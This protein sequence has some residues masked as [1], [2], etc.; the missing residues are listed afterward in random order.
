MF[1]LFAV[2]A[3]ILSAAFFVGNKILMARYEMPWIE[4][5]RWGLGATSLCGIVAYVLL[6]M[7]SLPWMWV[8]GAGVS[9]AF[10][11]VLA[12]KALSWGDA[13]FL[14]PISGA[15]PLLVA[16]LPLVMGVTLPDTIIYACLLSTLGIAL[17]VMIPP[18]AHKYA[19]HPYWGFF[20]MWISVVF[21]VGSDVCGAKAAE[22]VG[23]QQRFGIIAG[24][25]ICMGIAPMLSLGSHRHRCSWA[26]RG[27]AML[28]GV[29]FAA[30]LGCM[31]IAFTLAPNSALAVAEVNI[32][33]AFRGLV[34][35]LMVLA[36]DRWLALALEPLPR[37]IHAV[38]LI[39]SLVLGGAVV[40]AFM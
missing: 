39:G 2:L 9:G 22:I 34:S 8:I 5:W 7:P 23:Q 33:M 40:I 4:V 17:S 30:F 20:A 29:V 21:M 18:R 25:C 10:A 24:W 6:G 3:T 19:P 32:V 11:H 14:I 35:V 15:K 31:T 1:L 12:N 37:W 36:L 28:L 16:L 13:S 27:G 26:V 38:R